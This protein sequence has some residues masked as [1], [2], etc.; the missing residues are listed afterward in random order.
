MRRRFILCA[1]R[2]D[3]QSSLQVPLLSRNKI[4]FL[5]ILDP[6]ARAK[7]PPRKNACQ[8][9]ALPDSHCTRPQISFAKLPT[10]AHS[11]A[12]RVLSSAVLSGSIPAARR[13]SLFPVLSSQLE[14]RPPQGVPLLQF[15]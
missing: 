1:E 10:F 3:L 2:Y 4:V 12:Q 5:I 6:P 14:L 9:Q 8:I 7:L 15:F 13:L 11:A